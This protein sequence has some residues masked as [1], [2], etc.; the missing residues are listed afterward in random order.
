[1]FIKYHI[2]EIKPKFFVGIKTSCNNIG[3]YK[4]NKFRFLRKSTNLEKQ[5]F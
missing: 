4:N 5:V 2:V 1:M 3:E